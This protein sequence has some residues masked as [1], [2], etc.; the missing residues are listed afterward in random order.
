VIDR[1]HMARLKDIIHIDRAFVAKPGGCP[2]CK[3]RGTTGRTIVMEIVTPDDKLMQYI[4]SGERI[5][6][7]EHWREQGGQTVIEHTIQKVNLGAIDPIMAEKQ[8]GP[9]TMVK[10]LRDHTISQVEINVAV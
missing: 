5:K 3:N 1:H 10:I 8:V 6:A 9:L 2:A 4:K 7:I